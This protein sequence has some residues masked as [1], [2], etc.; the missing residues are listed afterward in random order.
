MSGLMK[1]R[2]QGGGSKWEV[3]TRGVLIKHASSKYDT[4]ASTPGQLCLP[5]TTPL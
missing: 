5:L 1:R 3:V 2:G 4:L